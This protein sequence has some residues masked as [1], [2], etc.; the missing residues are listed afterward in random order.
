MADPARFLLPGCGRRL[1][2]DAWGGTAPPRAQ[3]GGLRA[4][5]R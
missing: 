3:W 5:L 1:G 2:R 4:L